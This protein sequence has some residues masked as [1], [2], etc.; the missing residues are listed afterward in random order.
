[1]M[2]KQLILTVGRE[3]GSG[4]HEIAQKLA[5]YYHLPLYDGNLLKEIAAGKNIDSNVLE[6]FDEAHK[7]PV[8]SRTVRGMS[9]SPEQNIANMEFQFLKKKAEEGESFVVVGRCAETILREFP[10]V[11]S[12]F[13]LGDRESKMERVSQKYHLSMEKAEKLML[14]T[15]KK[16]KQYHNNYCP[17]KWGDSR[18]YDISINSSRFGLEGSVKLLV[19]SIKIKT[20]E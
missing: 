19:E 16:R 14:Q 4:G 12:I 5:E 6:E 8:I 15:D 13:V 2:K 10:T 20:Q 18:N 7:K 3:F 9:N 11:I 1:M 17:I